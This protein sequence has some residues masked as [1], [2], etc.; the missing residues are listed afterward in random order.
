ML[1]DIELN[2]LRAGMV[3]DSAHNTWSSYAANGIPADPVV[4]F[5]PSYRSRG[6]R[7]RTRTAKGLHTQY[8]LKLSLNMRSN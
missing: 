2:P 7:Y 1:Q 3:T 6:N 5:P 4:N 8:V